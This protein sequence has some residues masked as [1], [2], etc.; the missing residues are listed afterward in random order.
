MHTFMSAPALGAD[1]PSATFLFEILLDRE[2]KFCRASPES[3]FGSS[4]FAPNVGPQFKFCSHRVEAAPLSNISEAHLLTPKGLG[5]TVQN[6]I[7]A[8]WAP[9]SC[10]LL[11]SPARASDYTYVNFL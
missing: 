9:K 3:L 6:S 5:E 2:F 4:N 10:D 8:F 7:F 1:D 11:I